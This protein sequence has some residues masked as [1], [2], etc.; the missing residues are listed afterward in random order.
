MKKSAVIVAGGTGV[1]MNAGI[2]KQFLPLG[3]RPILF[4]SLEQFYRYDSGITMVIAL[5]EAH[6]ARWEALCSEAGFTVPHVV[7]KGGPTRFDSVKNAL[8]LVPGDGLV[9]I[10]DG[11][12]PLVSQ[13]LIR[14]CFEKAE[15]EGNCIPLLPVSESL[16]LVEG[17]SSRPFDRGAARIVQTPQVFLAAE[18]REAYRQPN[19]EAFTD[20]ATVFEFAGGTVH[21][22]E[23]EPE[24]LKVTRPADLV[25]A[26]ALLRIGA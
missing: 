8:A 18:L 11:V 10:H 2:P 6:I 15:L 17:L 4:Y 7:V 12:R 1:R 3:G 25:M 16:R 9:A 22:T 19:R 13:E 5:P 20:D 21:F 23:G 14:R 24:N 26:E